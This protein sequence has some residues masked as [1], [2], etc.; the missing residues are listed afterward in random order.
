MLYPIELRA[1]R[2]WVGGIIARFLLPVGTTEVT[3]NTENE[4]G[5]KVTADSMCESRSLLCVLSVLRG[6]TLLIDDAQ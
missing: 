1:L 4:G 2:S 6:S 5:E 3:E